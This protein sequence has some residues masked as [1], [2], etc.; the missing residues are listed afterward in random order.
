MSEKDFVVKNGIVVN[1]AIYANSTQIAFSTIN[2]TS[3]GILA[4][5]TSIT[6]GNSSVNAVINSTAF[7]GT[8]ANATLFANTTLA[9][10][11][12]W[13]TGN[14]S[15]AF[16]NATT[17]SST[18]GFANATNG[19]AIN[20]TAAN[21]TNLAGAP[22]TAYVNTTGSYVLGGSIQI[23]NSTVSTSMAT[24]AL[25]VT[26]G[27][28]I[29]GSLYAN[30]IVSNNNVTAYSDAR[31]KENVNTITDALA[32]VKQLRGVSFTRDNVPNIGVIAQELQAVI[33]EVV[34]EDKLSDYRYLAVAYGN[35][36]GLLIEAIKEL[37]DK[38]D[39]K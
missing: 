5:T 17:V 19:L 8:S 23:T 38:V 37:S 39:A 25:R 13:I 24:G 16:T 22:A 3:S 12:G 7:S 28:G 15:A 14:A 10:V 27:V 18:L 31:L 9:T 26:G 33:P 36:V 29:A 30:V 6:I 20:G 32:K 11:Q 34:F 4:N 1:N 21:A 2:A 35:L